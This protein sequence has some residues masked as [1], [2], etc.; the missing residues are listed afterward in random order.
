[1]LDRP[2]YQI[3][4]A[5]TTGGGEARGGAAGGHAQQRMLALEQP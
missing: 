4:L 1:M 5:V 2:Q 3:D